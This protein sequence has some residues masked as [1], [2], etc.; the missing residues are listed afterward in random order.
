[1]FAAENGHRD[2]QRPHTALGVDLLR[3]G[4][5]LAGQHQEVVPHRL[6]EPLLVQAGLDDGGLRPHQP[7]SHECSVA[8]LGR[9]GA[10][11]QMTSMN[12]PDG[13]NDSASG[14]ILTWV[15]G[16]HI[17]LGNHIIECVT[18]ITS[19]SMCVF[20]SCDQGVL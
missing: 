20:D 17:M 19:L 11:V 18:Y 13:K 16:K 15:L 7:L 8:G 10:A 5:H 14:N 12:L 2:G 6:A 3:P 4:G 9:H 1:M